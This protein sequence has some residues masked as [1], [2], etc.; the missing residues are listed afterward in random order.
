MLRRHDPEIPPAASSTRPI[1]RPAAAARGPARRKAARVSAARWLG[2]RTER[3]DARLARTIDR[4]RPEVLLAFSDV[5]SMAALPLC[6]R[7]G[8]PT[9]VSM[10]H[11]DVR[12]EQELLARED[13][14]VARFHADLPGRRRSRPRPP[15]LAARAPAPRPRA[16]RSRARPLGAH[17]RNVGAARNARRQDPCD[18]LRRR[19]PPVPPARGK[20]H[21]SDCTFLFAGGISQRKGIKYLLEAWRRIRRP[22]WRLQL[23]GPLPADLGPLEPYLEM[24]EPLGRVSHA[25]MPARMAAA[26]VFVFPSLFEGSAVVTYEA[27][28]SGLPSVVTP[29][30]RLGRPRRHRRLR[31]PLRETSK[32]WRSGWSSSAMTPSCAPAWPAQPALALWHST[33]RATTTRSSPPSMTCSAARAE[34]DQKNPHVRLR[35]VGRTGDSL[36]EQPTG[37][38]LHPGEMSGP[39]GRA[40]LRLCDGRV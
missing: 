34:P 35:R 2:W 15:G 24:V 12:E 37:S 4:A 26:D 6:R 28:A 19:L 31:R 22:G 11:G 13:G 10:V 27:L 14:V 23:L 1:F 40:L 38:I 7:L 33:G 5:G 25:E 9:I 17:R 29:K 36:F 3:F 21:G 39:H 20:Q 16:G 18:P 32:P 30:R 8:I